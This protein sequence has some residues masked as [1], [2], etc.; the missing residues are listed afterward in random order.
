MKVVLAWFLMLMGVAAF[1][2]SNSYG[3]ITKKDPALEKR[4]DSLIEKMSVE[5]KIGQLALRDWGMYSKEQIPQIKQAIR[6]GKL[7][8]FLNVSM[9]QVNDQ[10]FA[11]LQK[12]AVEESP[13]GI[14]L[15]F[16]QD[17]I[18]GYK[19]I[20]PIPLGQAASWNADLVERGA[21]VAA[22]EA[23]A[24]GVR[25]TFA[26]MIDIARDP[27]W[28][29]IAESLGE[30]PLLASDLGVAMVKGFQTDDPSQPTSLAACAKHFVAYGAT[31]GG[32][33]YNSAYV[34]EGILRDI[35]LKPFKAAVDAGLMTIMSS[36]NALNDIPATANAF[37]L[38]TILRDEW[39]FNGF[40][41]S[42]WNSVLEMIPHGFAKDDRHAAELSANAGIDFEMH[43]D[44]YERY[45]PDLIK[46]GKFSEEDLNIAVRNILRVKMMLGLWE[47][48]Y[49]VGNQEDT[50]LNAD[51]LASAKEAAEQS[52]VLLKNEGN[53]LPLKKSQKVAVIG[54]LADAAHEQLGTWIYDGE[55]KD[56]RTVLPA[57]K[58]YVGD[59]ANILYA[60]GVSYSRDKSTDG[61]AAAIAAA[62]KAD[63][64][65]YIGGEESILSGEG[66]S[67]G[68]IRLPGVQQALIGELA[69][70][71][72]P[73]V[74]VIMAGRLIQLD[75]TLTQSDALMMAWHPGTM[76]GPALVDV[77]YGERS[78][79]G[80][81]PLTWPITVGQI[82]YYYNHLATGRPASDDNY[83]RIDDIEQEIFQHFPGNSSN[84]LD[85]G[86]L[87]QFP[88]G[89][90]LTYSTFSYDKVK[91]NKSKI[92]LGK[93]LTASVVIKNTGK[94]TATEVVQLY[95]QD[96]VGS[97]AR[98]V[99][100]LKGYQRVT[101]APGKSQKV[102]FELHTDNLAFHNPSMELVTEPGEFNLWIAPNAL[103]GKA[104]AFEVQ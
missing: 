97:R 54:P 62:K 56:T 30:D 53:I 17:V 99:R 64:I 84:L 60:P 46:Q 9:S 22:L 13:N 100:E 75:Q 29:R 85:L 34:P 4:I 51:F 20:F 49:P 31:E 45:L 87:P 79:V 42:D 58:K 19:T 40:V 81:L 50:F 83:T 14:P 55:K 57:L 43:S 39:G 102:T 76:G 61:F 90:G 16:G 86:H 95:V 47:N 104:L 33:D 93:S 7:G 28:G 26:P 52:F 12:V 94:V 11:E 8:G 78:P 44:S 38:K 35:Y 67:R 65:L 74:Q 98:P 25:W 70:L 41:V 2:A 77:L 23:S 80:R 92:K 32:R 68:D 66:H 27:R 6:E 91:I 15:I 103:A 59:D 89:Y 18:H 71:D 10:A 48:P 88:F 73:L 101:L 1:A 72:K 21:R 24:D 69:K 3:P 82:P 5:E 37:T 96:K 63:V 36:Y